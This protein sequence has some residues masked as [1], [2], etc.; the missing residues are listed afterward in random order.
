[1]DHE[2]IENAI[3]NR[4]I[5]RILMDQQKQIID[6]KDKEIDEQ[7]QLLSTVKE[8]INSMQSEDSTS[9]R[10]QLLAENAALRIQSSENAEAYRMER[11]DR[12]MMH[13]GMK[14]LKRDCTVYT[15]ERDAARLRVGAAETNLER[16]QEEVAKLTDRI[17]QMTCYR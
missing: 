9:D 15:K 4:D 10:S 16:A 7:K 1:M 14:Q 5:D 3:R 11:N 6:Q 13:Q 2:E 12:V 8:L 17:Q